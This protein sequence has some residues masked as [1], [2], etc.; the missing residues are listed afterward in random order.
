MPSFGECKSAL[1][2]RR[3][4]RDVRRSSR[5]VR[6]RSRDLRRRSRDVGKRS[7]DV[8]RRSYFGIEAVSWRE[9]VI[10]SKAKDLIGIIPPIG[11]EAT[12][13]RRSTI[14]SFA[15]LRMTTNE[16]R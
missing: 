13:A 1:G 2:D 14:R 12:S 7:S 8:C 11:F 15:S 4:S 5:D 6:R 9:T 3:R 10:L 16:L